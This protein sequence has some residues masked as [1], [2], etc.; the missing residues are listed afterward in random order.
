MSWVVKQEPDINMPHI[1]IVALFPE[2]ARVC[3]VSL[4]N[5][6][7]FL[8]NQ[9]IWQTHLVTHLSFSWGEGNLSHEFN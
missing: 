8:Y 5:Y 3:T 4:V 2:S 6:L 9:T 7:I 1:I